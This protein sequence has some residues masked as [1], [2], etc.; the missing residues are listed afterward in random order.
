MVTTNDYFITHM[1]LR[2]LREQRVK[3][4]RVYNELQQKVSAEPTNFG[5]LRVLYNGLRQVAFANQKLHPNVVNLELLLWKNGAELVSE[6][7]VNFWL[8]AMEDELR[9]GQLRS[10]IVY[11]FG[12]I[13]EN[14]AS[15]ESVSTRAIA[16][17]EQVQKTQAERLLS[18][19]T[20]GNYTALLDTLFSDFALSDLAA[21]R[22]Q[23]QK[24]A[25][26]LLQHSIEQEELVTV[27]RQLSNSPY[28]SFKI[29]NQARSFASDNIIQKE[30]ADALTIMIE[31]IDEWQRPQEGV[32]VRPLW[33]L[34]KW[35]LCIDEDL[36]TTC[37]LEILGQRWQN[38]FEKFFGAER[39]ARRHNQPPSAQFKIPPPYRQSWHASTL[40]ELETW[41]QE[42]TTAIDANS[43]SNTDLSDPDD[44]PFGLR[45][46]VLRAYARES[47]YTS[48]LVKRREM[49][50]K[51]HNIEDLSSYDGLKLA[52]GMEKALM[53][54][55]AEIQLAQASSSPLALHILKIDLKHFYPGISHQVLQ[56]I[57]RRYGL[58]DTQLAFFETFMRVPLQLDGQVYSSERGVPLY[59][60][61]SDILAEL[62]MGLFEQHVEQNAQVE[63]IR[64]VDDICVLAYSS[65]EMLKAWRAILQF[66][67]LC[68]LAF[69][70][71]KCGYTCINAERLSELPQDLPGWMLLTLNERCQWD[72]NWDAFMR[73]VEL[74]HQ[75]VMQNRSLVSRIETYNSHLQHLIKALGLRANLGD[76]HRKAVNTAMDQ[77]SRIC[78]NEDV[79]VVE[80]IRQVIREHFLEEGSTTHLPEAWLY[81]PIT[82]GGC[83]LLN[84]AMI[85]ANYNLSFSSQKRVE[86]PKERPANWLA[87]NKEWRTFYESFLTEIYTVTPEDTQ[88]MRMLT[89]DFIARGSEMTNSKQTDLSPYWRWILSIYGP[90]ILDFLGTFRFLITELVPLQLIIQKYRQDTS[91]EARED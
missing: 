34:N 9:K 76:A 8:R 62:V 5:R 88:E 72:V 15:G 45:R 60:R 27:L 90:Q 24:N 69:N 36:P 67:E 75:Q 18:P 31:H 84:A 29:R 12:A 38:T 11:V 81:W 35:R 82:A 28:H 77:F 68:G 3:L 20:T 44:H 91:S 64:M 61:L 33:T 22:E 2:E 55:N 30:L 49:V 19:T 21:R 37:F 42:T 52:S 23:M 85:A 87:D 73:Y 50:N 57:L 32:P 51:L 65:D 47:G 80:A 89:N 7:T 54:V 43:T 63:I 86:A 14:W 59:H 26:S 78:F 56:D 17:R 40:R 16:E 48:I 71:E 53:L 13:L 6:E 41:L 46:N 79:P 58:T 39:E 25:S 1:K 66:C 83:G 74:A 70:K 4:T 10:E